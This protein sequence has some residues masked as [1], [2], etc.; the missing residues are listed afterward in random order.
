MA[1]DPLV[2]FTPSGR[3]GRFETGTTVL[4][5]ARRLGVDIDSVCGGRGIC[6]RCQVEQSVGEFAKHGITS[7]PDH[8][9]PFGPVEAEYRD[10]QGPRRRSGGSAAPPT[11]RATSSSTSRRRARS[12]ARSSARASTSATST[13]IPVVRLHYVEVEPPEL[14][15]PSGD[16]HRLQ[17]SLAREWDLHDLETDLHVIRALQPALEAG[18]YGVTVAVH[19]RQTITARLARAPRPGLRRRD[20]HRLDD[21]RRP[22]RE[23]RRRGGARERRR[24]EPPDPVRR[25]PDEPGQLR[26]DER[27]RGG[28][29][30]RCRAPGAQRPPGP[31]RQPRRD[32]ARRDPRAGGGGQ[33]DHAPPPARHRPDPARV[34]AVRAGDG[35]GA[36]RSGPTSWTC[37]PIPAPGSTSCRAS[38]ATSGP[39]RPA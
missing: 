19:D 33:P 6:G 37:S 36:S 15:S 7:A 11:S 30:D 4:D 31:A 18:K 21:D 35:P 25:G 3:R 39:T 27:R 32:Q 29:D 10:A 38:R 12:T 22:P 34:G 26:D 23:P 5:A 2:I 8:L 16:L 17:E 24:H 13:S 9:T 1:V 14:A 28:R 20:R